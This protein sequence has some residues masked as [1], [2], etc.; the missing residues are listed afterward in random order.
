[1]TARRRTRFGLLGL[2]EDS[3]VQLARVVAG[4]G[5]PVAQAVDAD[6]H[7]PGNMAHWNARGPG[8]QDRLVAELRGIRS[9][10][11]PLDRHGQTNEGG[12]GRAIRELIGA[13]YHGVVTSDRD[14]GSVWLDPAFR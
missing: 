12:G 8:Q 11:P 6:A 1:M 2:G 4:L 10:V 5:D 3:L 13:D 9:N 14:A 7:F